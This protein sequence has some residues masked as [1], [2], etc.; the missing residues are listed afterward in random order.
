MDVQ[1]DPAVAKITS[2]AAF[3]VLG[4]VLLF[5]AEAQQQ[6]SETENEYATYLA[7]V[8]DLTESGRR[9]EADNV[10]AW[11]PANTLSDIE[12]QALAERLSLALESVEAFIH[13]PR[14]WQ[15]HQIPV[16]E[17]YFPSDRFISRADADGRVFISY[18]R[19]EAE[20]APILHETVHAILNP[21]APYWPWEY[22]D[23]EQA[24]AAEA[25]QAA[26]LIEGLADYVAKVISEQTGIP[27]GDVF[28]L[29]SV[30]EM[31]TGCTER[32]TS[33][34]GS[35]IAPFIGAP[36]L[37]DRLIGERRRDFA[38]VFYGCSAS[39]NKFLVER[40]GIETVVD[41]IAES[42]PHVR[43]EELMGLSMESLRSAWL[44]Q[45]GA[46]R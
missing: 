37:P 13:A 41:L 24:R 1:T 45:I 10:V 2:R 21:A 6:D 31:D 12:G 40:L 44:E 39:F 11:V 33:P 25:S 46:D 5:G 36:G 17:Y 43:L 16:V 34:A 22:P 38:P 3:V 26:W 8:A 18:W 29:G 14:Q 35:E 23:Q 15:R 42:D 28:N 7:Y 20:Q 30:D 4:G 9:F 19:V 27:E 32:L